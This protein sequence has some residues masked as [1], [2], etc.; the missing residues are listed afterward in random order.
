MG[1][2]T[3]APA[4]LA[5]GVALLLAAC[6]CAPAPR[7]DSPPPPPPFWLPADLNGDNAIDDADLQ[8]FR[9]AWRAYYKQGT[10]NA[11]AD[12]NDDKRID[13]FDALTMAGYMLSP[14]GAVTTAGAIVG[15]MQAPAGP[16]AYDVLLDGV[17]V[18]WQ[19][20]PDGRFAING[21]PPGD[22]TLSIV[23]RDLPTEGYHESVTVPPAETVTL[24][25][26][27]RPTVGGQIAGLVT[28]A[29][30]LEPIAGAQVVTL[31]LPVLE[32]P[33]PPRITDP[34]TQAADS[35][36]LEPP[37]SGPLLQTLTDRAGSYVL[38]AVPPGAYQVTVNA[39]GY[40]PQ[41]R[42]V[43]VVAGR[44]SPADFA[45]RRE[46]DPRPQPGEGAIEGTVYGVPA[47]ARADTDP[48]RAV[49]LEGALVCL[50]SRAPIVLDPEFPPDVP[51]ILEPTPADVDPAIYP[52]RPPRVL[53]PRLCTYTDRD[54]HYSLRA[55]AGKAL[56]TVRAAGYLPVG[57]VVE[58]LEGRTVT[59]DVRLRAGDPQPPS[60]PRL[61][62]VPVP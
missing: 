6:I 62:P 58:I 34:Q 41:S 14:G 20:Q 22:H 38:A 1:R 61:E 3:L 46:P 52:P 31:P 27:V 19:T 49:T 11:A 42:P 55:P 45:L 35:P 56:L 15:T 5:G 26:P 59:Q 60:P 57:L 32:P 25:E 24:P 39:L 23:R 36:I 21:V 10:Y 2:A 4:F 47:D 9:Q 13:Y 12:L 40:V 44:T 50:G 7:A 28:D 51:H 48:G 30:T 18:P 17:P 33:P 16:D 53:L 54:G 29:R 37:S 43:R 8:L